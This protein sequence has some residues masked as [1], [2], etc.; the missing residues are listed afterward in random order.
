MRESN[1]IRS[2]YRKYLVVQ[3]DEPVQLTASQLRE[4]YGF[5]FW[6]S[7]ILSAA[8]A[9]GATTIYTEDMQSG[10]RI[11]QRLTILNPFARL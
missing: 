1:N 11:N 3:V 10:L 4:M 9:G 5:S 7:L 8:F 6:D 2:F